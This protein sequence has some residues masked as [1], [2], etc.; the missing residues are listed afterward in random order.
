MYRTLLATCGP[1]KMALIDSTE[2]HV[3]SNVRYI[4]YLLRGACGIWPN[5]DVTFGFWETWKELERGREYKLEGLESLGG[6]LELFRDS[7]TLSRPPTPSQSAIF[8]I[9][10]REFWEL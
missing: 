1:V 5:F 10:T 9:I 3:A 2:P 7:H 4:A 8:E 6:L